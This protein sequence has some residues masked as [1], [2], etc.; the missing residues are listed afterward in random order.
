MLRYR[1]IDRR[2]PL[3]AVFGTATAHNVE[4]EL[5]QR[6]S[7]GAD[8]AIADGAMVYADD[9]ANLRT[10]T[11]EKHLVGDV[12]FGTVNLS[13]AGDV[14]EFTATQFHH[15]VTS[16][17]KQDIFGG[18]RCDKFAVDDQEDVF[19]APFGD[20]PIMSE[21]NRLIE[22]VL[23]RL[24]FRKGRVDIRTNNFGTCRDSVIVYAPP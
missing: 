4:V 9:R 16:D 23:H 18:G 2:T 20:M 3:F 17:A 5:L 14:P 6:A 22:P 11:A 24:A 19:R 1:S 15:S 10:G 21:H 8:S 12:E 7:D 13:L